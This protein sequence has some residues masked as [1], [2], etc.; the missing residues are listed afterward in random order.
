[1]S[2]RIAIL[3]GGRIPFQPSGTVYKN[4]MGYDLIKSA[5]N[6][7]FDKVKISPGSVDHVL[8]GNVIQEVKTSNVAREASWA[9]NIP[10]TTPA[11]T[12]SQACISSSQCVTMGV[13]QIRSGQAKIVLAGG[14]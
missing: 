11:T 1:M 14:V 3:G 8:V 13:N 5:I 12:I 9:T 10:Y 2:A 7:L 4:H 6:G